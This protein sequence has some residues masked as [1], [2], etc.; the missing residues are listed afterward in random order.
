M[1]A[2]IT[3]HWKDSV[4]YVSSLWSLCV[5]GYVVIF[6]PKQ[7]IFWWPCFSTAWLHSLRLHLI[8]KEW[9]LTT[10]TQ[11]NRR[12]SRYC[13]SDQKSYDNLLNIQFYNLA[14]MH[15]TPQIGF[16]SLCFLNKKNCQANTVLYFPILPIPT[17]LH[18]MQLQLIGQEWLFTAMHHLKHRK[19]RKESLGSHCD[20]MNT[21]SCVKFTKDLS[22]MFQNT[23]CIKIF[24]SPHFLNMKPVSM[25]VG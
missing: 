24:R 9:W 5:L 20:M 17:L 6:K 7:C 3:H 22:I 14:C 15:N 4:H 11:K 18:S 23:S 2:C 10:K 19:M 1:H 8:G 21:W 25:L 16:S 12:I 13:D